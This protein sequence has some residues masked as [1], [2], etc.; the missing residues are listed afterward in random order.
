MDINV[1]TNGPDFQP[2][3]ESRAGRIKQKPGAVSRLAHL[4]HFVSFN[5]PNELI[6][7]AASSDKRDGLAACRTPRPSLRFTP[8][9]RS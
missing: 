4:A 7:A 9:I 8:T 1:E 3:F 6:C 5:F 2:P